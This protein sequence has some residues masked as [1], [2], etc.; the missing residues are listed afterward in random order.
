[1]NFY[2]ISHLIYCIVGS[3]YIKI[4]AY[5][6]DDLIGKLKSDRFDPTIS[7]KIEP[8]TATLFTTVNRQNLER[9]KVII[10]LMCKNLL[11]KKHLLGKIELNSSHEFWKEVIKA[12]CNPITKT[13]D[14]ESI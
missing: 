11:G 13:I 9:V 1:M 14:M 3:L 6:F 12:P 8:K 4:T 2:F 10:R 5:E 7:L